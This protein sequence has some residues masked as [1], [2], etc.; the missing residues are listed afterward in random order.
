LK[1]FKR[2]TV[3]KGDQQIVQFR[4]PLQELQKWDLQNHQWKIYP[5][6]Y[7]ILIGTNS[8]DV[9]LRSVI[10]IKAGIK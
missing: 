7:S 1:A 9:K 3:V 6:E 10:N 5:G 8:E 2:I 4:I